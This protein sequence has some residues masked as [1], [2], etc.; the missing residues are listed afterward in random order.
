M[1]HPA[2]KSHLRFVLRLSL[3]KGGSVFAGHFSTYLKKLRYTKGEGAQPK[4]YSVLCRFYHS[5]LCR[6]FI[7]SIAI[8]YLQNFPVHINK[9][10]S[11]FSFLHAGDVWFSLNGT[12]YY[13]NSIVTLED[14]GNNIDTALLCMT[15][16][17]ACCRPSQ[18]NGFS[19]G[20]WYF[21]NG[22]R[23]PNDFIINRTIGLIW[24]FYRDRGLMVVRM[25]R[26]GGGV[27]GIYHCE[28]PDSM[29][30]TQTIYIGVYNTS[31]GEV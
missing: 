5:Q 13:N 10:I 11:I 12:T 6:S 24:D 26:R 4:L 22:T 21:P 18:A 9:D 8:K 3:Q 14:I 1:S 27:E 16:L 28:I 29:N 31:S 25:K 7:G 15:N 2:Y 17:T 23:V 20:N 30:V 19:L